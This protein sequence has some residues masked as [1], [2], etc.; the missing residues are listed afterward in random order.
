MWKKFFCKIQVK[1][2]LINLLIYHLYGINK[3]VRLGLDYS[4]DD[5]PVY[6]DEQIEKLCFCIAA[7]GILITIGG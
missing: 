2:E 3:N 1:H 4:P 5:L 7:D 6:C